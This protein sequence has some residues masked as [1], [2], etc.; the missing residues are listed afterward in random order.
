MVADSVIVA[1][2]LSVAAAVPRV[3]LFWL[4]SRERTRIFSLALHAGRTDVVME[5]SGPESARLDL[6]AGCAERGGCGD[7]R[8]DR[9]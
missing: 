3:V 5:H 9:S 6:R 1:V 7:D 4:M 8:V 2:V